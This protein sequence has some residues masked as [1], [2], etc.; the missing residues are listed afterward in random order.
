MVISILNLALSSGGARIIRRSSGGGGGGGSSS[1]Q[2]SPKPSPTVDPRTGKQMGTVEPSVRETGLSG[3]VQR[4][5]EKRMI[6]QTKVSRQSRSGISTTRA[7]AMVG[8]VSVL[9]T[10]GGIALEY[11]DVAKKIPRILPTGRSLLRKVPKASQEVIN[12]IKN[13]KASGLAIVSAGKGISTD[14]A[15][16][17]KK[18]GVAFGNMVRTSP[19]QAIAVVGTHIL[20]FAGTGKALKYTGRLVEIGSARL[21]PKFVGAIKTGEKVKIGLTKDK[22]VFVDA[23]RTSSL[24]KSKATRAAPGGRGVV[25]VKKGKK[26]ELEFVGKIP[27]ESIGKQVRR[28][29][30]EATPVSSQAD[31]LVKLIKRSK[32]VR[33]PIPDEGK[34]TT[35]A[36]N[37]L[38]KFDEKTINKRE[39][40]ELDKIVKQRSGKGILERSFFADPAGRVRPSRLGISKDS[41]AKILD[42]LSGDVSFRKAKPQILVFSKQRVQSFPKSLRSIQRKLKAGRPLSKAEADKFLEW[43]QKQSGKFK[44]VGFVSGEAEIT[45]APGEVIKRKKKIGVTLINGRKVPIIQVEVKKATRTTMDLLRKAG[46]GSISKKEFTKLK[47]SLKRETGFKIPSSSVKVTGKRVSLKRL[48]SNLASRPL[49]KRMGVKKII[50]PSGRSTKPRSPRR[51]GKSGFSPRKIKRKSGIRF[52]RSGRPS[53]LKKSPASSPAS[54]PRRKKKKIPYASSG[55]KGSRAVKR[56]P[57]RLRSKKKRK[58]RRFALGKK[59]GYHVFGKSFG[60]SI[61]LTKRPLRK[62]DAKNRGAYATDNTTSKT[63]ITKSAGKVKRFGKIKKWE[64]GYSKKTKG[65]FRTYRIKKGKAVKFKR[66][67]SIEKRKFGIDTSG[68]KRQ[69]SMARYARGLKKGKN[70]AV[71][72]SKNSR[73]S[74]RKQKYKYVSTG[75]IFGGRRRVLVKRSPPR[76]KNIQRKKSRPARRARRSRGIFG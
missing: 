20:I 54:S 35:R 56:A 6:K 17:I 49:S 23:R 24:F 4:A 42:I 68:E 40:I 13:P 70:I 55:G 65:K 5:S 53:S 46:K 45:L 25:S 39:L 33:K 32:I 75:G 10:A 44:P 15:K 60:K 26:V 12:A 43:Q 1:P 34:L 8:G 19:S 61:R 67:R 63:F 64:K 29:G 11:W 48:G 52:R 36:K 7:R 27:K 14:I 3:L 41:D 66:E 76:R 2:P 38:V 59:A 16:E 31:S 58:R 47:K 37:L 73:P 71:R 72:K 18:E 57:M 74:R 28:A 50:R 22:K 9:E 21:S 51:K 69:L 62:I 30:K